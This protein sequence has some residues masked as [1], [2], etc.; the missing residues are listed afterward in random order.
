MRTPAGGQIGAADQKRQAGDAHQDRIRPEI[1]DHQALRRRDDDAEQRAPARTRAGC[2]ADRLARKISADADTVAPRQSDMML[3]VS[4]MKVM[5]TAT[6]PMNEIA[7]SSA[8]ML[9]GEVKPGV[10]QRKHRNGDAPQMRTA[11]SDAAPTRADATSCAAP[12]SC[13]RDR[14]GDVGQHPMQ[15]R[16]AAAVVSDLPAAI[17]AD[18]DVGHAEHLLDVGRRH[19]EA[20]AAVAELPDQAVDFRPRADVDPAGRLVHQQHAGLVAAD[21]AAECELLLVAAAQFVGLRA[22]PRPV[23]ADRGGELAPRLARSRRGRACRAGCDRQAAWRRDSGRRSAGE[24][25]LRRRDPRR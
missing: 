8:L 7:L 9:S 5:P 21:G 25:R 12:R 23:D 2:R 18:D 3:P 15:V 13:R 16:L 19:D 1:A 4:V 24:T 11:G 17:H 6:Q 22:Q 10:R 14:V 20:I